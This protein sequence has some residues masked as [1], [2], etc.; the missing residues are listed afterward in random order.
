MSLKKILKKD[1]ITMPE[2]GTVREAAK[3]MYKH[4]IG[5]VVVVDKQKPSK[6]IPI[7]IV[8]DRDIALAYGKSQKLASDYSVK[9]VMTPN[10][11]ICSP[12]EGIYQGH[13]QDAEKRNQAHTGCG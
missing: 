3:L 9:K 11:V 12:D 7:G 5:T 2:T 13:L 6:K 4:H 10:I 8:T 1:V